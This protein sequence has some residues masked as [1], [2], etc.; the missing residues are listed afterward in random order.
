MDIIACD[1]IFFAR[2]R[3]HK[4]EVV[5][6]EWISLLESASVAIDTKETV[7][8]TEWSTIGMPDSRLIDEILTQFRDGCEDFS[9]EILHTSKICSGIVLSDSIE[10]SK[11]GRMECRHGGKW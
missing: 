9:I 10:E 3:D 11:G 8:R 7:L 6:V 4:S 2:G 1:G 5:L